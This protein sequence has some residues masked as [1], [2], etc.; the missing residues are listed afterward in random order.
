[1]GW[2]AD[3]TRTTSQ[4]TASQGR[5]TEVSASP[6]DRVLVVTEG[7]R[8]E[9]NYFGELRM[10]YRLM[11]AQVV[12]RPCVSGTSPLQVVDY[13]LKLLVEGDPHRRIQP[14]AF[15]Q[16]YAVFDRDDHEGFDAAVARAESLNRTRRNDER[17]EVVFRAIVS[18]PCFELWPLLHFADY[19]ALPVRT[20]VW[21]RLKKH[22]PEY[23]KGA[24][25][26][27]ARTRHR[28]QDAM[29]RAARLEE[30]RE[31]ADTPTPYT[32]IGKLV[33]VFTHLKDR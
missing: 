28:L 33:A 30:Q 16:V 23:D 14:G 21:R 3:G 2:P 22:L 32:E 20:E 11:S 4:A 7:L 12:I 13:A 6:Y 1:M 27:F 19:R 9:P 5:Q 29:D 26:L 17:R 10:H 18:N 31:I 15:E 25:D 8:T 24:T